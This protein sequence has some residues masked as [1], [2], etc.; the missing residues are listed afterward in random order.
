ME[1]NQIIENVKGWSIAK[2]LDGADPLKQM[3]KLNEEWGGLN[4]GKAKGNTA[5]ITDS[6]GDVLVVLTILAQQMKFEKIEWLINPKVHGVEHYVSSDV[7]VDMLLLYGTKEIGLIA[8][9]L[10]DLIYTPRV[11]NTRAQIQFHIRNLTGVL[12]K[13]AINEGTTIDECLETAWNEI[14]DRTGKTV[15]GV[16]VKDADLEE[17]GND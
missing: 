7:S 16:F 4:E 9:R 12:L 10:I 8:Q 15:D 1:F 5:Q 11:I 13:V 3:Q 2:G 6:I 14:K 17:V